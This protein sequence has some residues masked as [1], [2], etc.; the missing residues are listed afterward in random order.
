MVQSTSARLIGGSRVAGSFVLAAEESLTLVVSTSSSPTKKLT[1]LLP[2]DDCATL[3]SV[4]DPAA[5]AD[6]SVSSGSKKSGI[7]GWGWLC[8]NLAIISVFVW[9]NVWSADTGGT[10]AVPGFRR[11]RGLAPGGTTGESISSFSFWIWSSTIRVAVRLP[12]TRNP[13]LA[14]I[15]LMSSAVVFTFGVRGCILSLSCKRAGR[16]LFRFKTKLGVD[17]SPRLLE[18]CLDCKTKLGDFLSQELLLVSPTDTF[19]SV[20]LQFLDTAPFTICPCAFVLLSRLDVF[21]GGA[22]P[23]GEVPFRCRF[24]LFAAFV[25]ETWCAVEPGVEAA[26]VAGESTASGDSLELN[27]VMLL[28]LYG[29]DPSPG[30]PGRLEVVDLGDV[31]LLPGWVALIA[32]RP[33]DTLRPG[34]AGPLAGLAGLDPLLVRFNCSGV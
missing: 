32:G 28:L 30:V 6:W 23:S 1:S 9:V 21:G 14:L 25:L 3:S 20:W 31:L 26:V 5:T 33:G 27:C 29:S 10:T 15:S 18:P 12:S 7:S 19:K 13:P 34:V 17:L 16:V 2:P 4:P 11:N 22:S 8:R 24:R